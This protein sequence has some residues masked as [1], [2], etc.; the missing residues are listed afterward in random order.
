MTLDGT[1]AL[2]VHA[3]VNG[4]TTPKLQC[5]SEIFGI[6]AGSGC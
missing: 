5:E 1:I 3:D 4:D 6:S 2:L